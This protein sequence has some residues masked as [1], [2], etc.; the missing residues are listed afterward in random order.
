M[1][2][3]DLLSTCTPIIHYSGLKI[4]VSIFFLRFTSLAV[5]AFCLGRTVTTTHIIT[6]NSPLGIIAVIIH[7]SASNVPQITFVSPRYEPAQHKNTTALFTESHRGAV[8]P[9]LLTLWVWIARHFLVCVRLQTREEALCSCSLGAREMSPSQQ[10]WSRACAHHSFKIFLRC[11]LMPHG[12]HTL[13]WL[14]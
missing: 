6:E 7:S 10:S 3:N 1:K 11:F 14:L 9:N 12:E 5:K 2:L 8:N 13:F 4:N